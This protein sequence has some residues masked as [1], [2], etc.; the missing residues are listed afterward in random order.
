[1]KHLCEKKNLNYFISINMSYYFCKMENKI[2]LQTDSVLH[3]PIKKYDNDFTFIVNSEKY[4]TSSIAADLLSPIIS[5]RHLIDPTLREF[6][7][8]TNNHGDFNLLLNLLNFESQE[9]NSKDFQFVSEVIEKLGTDKIQLI[10]KIKNEELTIDNIFDHIEQHQS[11]PQ[12]YKKEL[13]SEINFFSS[14]F[15]ELKEK[16]IQKIKGE[17]FDLNEELIELIINNCHLVLDSEN[18]L[19][20]VINQL[21]LKNKNYSNL[22]EFVDFENVELKSMKEFIQIFDMND[23]TKPT[24]SSLSFRL[25][26]EILKDDFNIQ[27]SKHKN[28]NKVIEIENK[29]N[30]FDGIL[31]YLQTHYDI[32]DEIDITYSTCR[33]GDP[34]N[35]LQYDNKENYFISDNFPNSWICFEFKNYKIIPT[36]YIIRSRN[37][38]NSNHLKSW[39]VEGSNDK[40]YWIKLD[41][42]INNCSLNGVS[43]VHSFSISY[44]E[45]NQQPFKYLRIRQIGPTWFY[46]NGTYS[47]HQLLMNSIEFYGKIISTNS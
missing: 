36:N 30:E 40:N 5:S 39:I 10:D 13:E 42:Q 37:N 8:N 29:F 16:V 31:N 38:E 17:K 11:H 26:H 15:F 41:E 20:E 46:F 32:K 19:L 44:D 12:F 1:M 21:Y 35:L 2:K 18:D 33:N 6:V 28:S 22:Y 7:I 3:I 24:W 43:V 25:G 14:H 9:I 23:M 4:E 47:T 34:F 45:N 27:N